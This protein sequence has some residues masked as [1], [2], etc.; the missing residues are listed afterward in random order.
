MLDTRTRHTN[1]LECSSSSRR[2]IFARELCP[3]ARGQKLSPLK[4]TASLHA[5][6]GLCGLIISLLVVE[7]C[8][9]SVK[10]DE[11]AAA[12]RAIEF[13][14]AAFVGQKFDEAYD[15]LS[16]GG[17]RHLS[18]EKFKQTIIRMHSRGFPTKVTAKEFQPM[19]GENAIW[20]YLVGQNSEDQFGYR[21]TMESDDHG[22][23]K[24]LTFDSGVV[25]RMFSP[26]S[27]KQ[28]FKTTFST[29]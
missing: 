8:A 6:A 10:H 14:Q 18:Q 24:V 2:A 22:D 28:P 12:R 13:A 27:E 7:A 3:K 21:L 1:S 25:G 19:P 29:R 15:L 9:R 16:V 17:K 20:I 23:Y 4:I 5:R 26:L 11:A